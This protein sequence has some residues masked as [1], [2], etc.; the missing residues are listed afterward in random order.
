MTAIS[1]RPA[2]L[3]RQEVHFNTYAIDLP[4]EDEGLVALFVA[5][6]QKKLLDRSV[7]LFRYISV[8]NGDVD[9]Q[10]PNVT[11]GRIRYQQLGNP[12][13]DDNQALFVLTQKVRQLDKNRPGGCTASAV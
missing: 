12:A 3:L 7:G 2:I 13:S 9:V 6:F 11:L 10:A 8:V 1:P 4:E 5:P